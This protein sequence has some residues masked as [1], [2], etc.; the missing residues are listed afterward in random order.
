MNNPDEE[1]QALSDMDPSTSCV[2]DISKFPAEKLDYSSGGTIDLVEYR[3]GFLKYQYSKD[4][5]GFAVFSEIYYPVGWK[6][7]IDG[8]PADIERVDYVLRGLQVPAGDHAIEFEFK[9]ASY[10]TGNKLMFVFSLGTILFFGF[11]SYVT[12]KNSLDSSNKT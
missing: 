10:Y 1:I 3:P 6:A 11:T 9:P 8:N 7:T 4:D 5:L 2:M 12:F